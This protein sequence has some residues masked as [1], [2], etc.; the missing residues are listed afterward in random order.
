MDFDQ[1]LKTVC[2]QKPTPEAYDLAKSA[3]EYAKKL[4]SIPDRV[5]IRNDKY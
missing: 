4:R 1:W 2:F 3:F 5:E